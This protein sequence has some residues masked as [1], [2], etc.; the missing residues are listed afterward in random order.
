MQHCVQEPA[1]GPSMITVSA[2]STAYPPCASRPGWPAVGG[3]PG[4][5][6]SAPAAG[7]FEG[8]APAASFSVMGRVRGS[9]GLRE[10]PGVAP[11]A[12]ITS[13][14]APAASIIISSAASVTAPAASVMAPA[15]SITASSTASI[16]ASAASITAPAAPGPSTSVPTWTPEASGPAL[17]PSGRAP[18]GGGAKTMAWLSLSGTKELMTCCSGRRP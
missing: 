12:S 2:S 17:A 13:I 6:G 10:V 9:P 11:A 5:G 15:A 8:I 4:S 14:T 7:T 16:T 1:S 3:A 18:G